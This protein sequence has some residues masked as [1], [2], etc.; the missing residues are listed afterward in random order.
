MAIPE[1]TIEEL[2]NEEWRPVVG[3]EGLYSISNLGRVR[4]EVDVCNRKYKKGRILSPRLSNVGYYQVSLFIKGK[5][6]TRTIHQLVAVAFIGPRPKGLYINHKDA[7]KANNRPE[8]LEYCTPRENLQHASRLGLMRSGD[9]HPSRLH[10]ETRAY[11][12]KNGARKHPER[13]SRGEKNG[14]AKIKDADVPRIF[15]LKRKGLSSADIAPLFG[16][17]SSCIRRIVRGET[18]VPYVP[19]VKEGS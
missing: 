17:S 13:M 9:K 1:F 15:E 18:H 16:V 12:D 3:Y 8:N 14:W 10:P 19:S 11:G 7:C 2:Q 5:G 4:G 6:K